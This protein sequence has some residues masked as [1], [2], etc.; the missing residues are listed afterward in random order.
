MDSGGR[1]RCDFN[2]GRFGSKGEM[3]GPG[4]RWDGTPIRNEKRTGKGAGGA[5]HMAALS[6]E[7]GGGTPVSRGGRGWWEFWAWWTNSAAGSAWQVG[8]A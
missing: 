1:H 6:R 2:G 8:P 7:N 5:W 4:R 3:E